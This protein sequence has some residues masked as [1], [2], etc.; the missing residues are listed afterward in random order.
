MRTF[1][2]VGVSSGIGY[3]V[4]QELLDQGNF[5]I[6][7]GRKNTIDHQNFEFL[8]LDL[9]NEKE[10]ALFSFP[11]LEDD[12]AFIYNAGTL[13]EIN[14]F[15]HQSQDNSKVVFQV[16]YLSATVLTHKILKKPNCKQIIYISSGAAKRA[17]PSWS[18][19]CASKAALDMFAE[20]VQLEFQNEHR[21]CKIFSIAPGVVDTPMQAQIRSTDEHH[22]PQVAHF[23]EL[24]DKQ[25]LTNPSEVA[26][27]LVYLMHHTNDFPN[28]RFSLR[29]VV[30]PN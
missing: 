30:I 23:Q 1:I 10:V 13:G 5:V 22:F 11:N 14:S 19:Y 24:H 9:N 28:V 25:E 6:G 3:S 2:V 15:V 16:N 20:T 17:M 8:H 7:L 12:F 21:S 26:R 4:V 18:Q 27:K 29:D